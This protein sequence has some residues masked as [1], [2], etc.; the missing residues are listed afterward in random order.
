MPTL[1][2]ILCTPAE[3]PNVVRDAAAL[4]ESEVKSKTGLTGLAV[5]AAFTVVTNI[6][7]GMIRD[8][9]DV[10]LDRFIDQMEPF[11]SDWSAAGRTEPLESFLN[12]RKTKVVAALLWVT[13]ERAKVVDSATLKKAYASLR[14]QGEKHVEAAIP[15]L[16]RMVGKYVR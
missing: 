12:A 10:L 8:V 9:V 5:K 1:R 6:K 7:P 15:G 4:V 2:E 16:A 3:R 14:P 11:F 13:D